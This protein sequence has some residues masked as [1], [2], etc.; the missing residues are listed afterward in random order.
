MSVKPSCPPWSDARVP[1]LTP[2]RGHGVKIMIDMRS[3]D[4]QG[5]ATARPDDDG[6]WFHD[7]RELPDPRADGNPDEQTG[8]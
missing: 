3:V 4:A 6:S 2:G 7:V 1:E 5:Q 8:S